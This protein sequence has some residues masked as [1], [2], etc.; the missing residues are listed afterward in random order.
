[1][2]VN[3]L[4]AIVGRPNVGKS[5]LFN[6]LIGVRRAITHDT[7]GTTRDP[8]YGIVE[9]RGKAFTL[10]D[11]A[12]LSK[13]ATGNQI[14]IASQ[15]QISQVSTTATIIVVV[16]DAANIITE[17]DTRAA[18][19]ALKTG[20]PV[21]L[22]LGKYDTAR[23][24]EIDAFRR[25]GIKTIVG[26]SAIHGQG[27][28]DLLDEIA[29]I[30]PDGATVEDNPPIR[31]ALLG[32]PNVG[33]SSIM[34]SL[35]GKQQAV[36]SDVAGT[37]R[38]VGAAR[39]KYKGREMELLDTAGLRR[40]GRIEKGI[41]KYSAMRTLGA[42]HEA[43]VCI[44]VMDAVDGVVAGGLNLA[45]Q[46]VE[47]GKGLIIVMNKWDAVEKDDKTQDHMTK[48]IQKSFQFV[49]WAPLVYTS[50]ITGL[51][52]TQLSEL[53][54]EIDDRRRQTI[55][56]G[57]LNRLIEGMIAKQPP[58]GKNNRQPK[59]KYATQTGD[60]PTAITFFASY[61]DMIHFSYK[62][63]LENGLREAYDFTGTPIRLLFRGKA[64]NSPGSE[65]E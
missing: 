22:A 47:A 57:P 40:R 17:E 31:L 46:V 56:T 4:V 20:K 36:V 65:A 26:V 50:A 7:A 38:D 12:G 43:D 53:V 10:V 54:L 3:H 11:T 8:N 63:Y 45:G 35:I 34:N 13:A 42:I 27:T 51:H 49:W 33:K 48:G 62:R 39:F 1:M 24:A 15:E 37:T 19:L 2:A 58:S 25:L 23:N 6:R 64:K 21:I 30:L 59:I 28:G 52:I 41:E 5:T 32:R 29:A 55:P 14:E 16:V 9:W 44:L 60:N 18:K 61:P